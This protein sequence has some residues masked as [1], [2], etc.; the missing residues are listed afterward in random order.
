MAT[1]DGRFAALDALPRNYGE[2]AGLD[3]NVRCVIPVGRL[4]FPRSGTGGADRVES[5]GFAATTTAAV[6]GCAAVPIV[7]RAESPSF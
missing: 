7:S 4:K 2:N 3:P 1:P 6:P 5:V